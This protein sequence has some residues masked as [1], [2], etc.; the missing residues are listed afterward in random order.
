MCRTKDGSSKENTFIEWCRK[1]AA[2]AQTDKFHFGAAS[3]ATE[4]AMLRK[5][6][7][8]YRAAYYIFNHGLPALLDAP[9]TRYTMLT[10]PMLQSMVQELMT[11]HASLLQSILDRQQ[12]PRMEFAHKCSAKDQ[13][14]WRRHRHEE[15]N[16]ARADLR[17]GEDLAKE[18]D[19][20]KRKFYTM[21]A[22]EQQLVEDYDCD[23]LNK[24]YKETKI[25]KMPPFRGKKLPLLIS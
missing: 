20:G 25:E 16:R 3:A 5:N 12:D 1:V 24:R 15:K 13:Q 19:S 7:G 8:D 4:H 17:E 22:T 9:L 18:R 21:S 23:R 6:V 11:W 2:H 14:E 10:K